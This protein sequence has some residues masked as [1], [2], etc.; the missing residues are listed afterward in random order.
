MAFEP[1]DEQLAILDH[2]PG[3]HARVLAGPGTGKST[4]MVALLDRLLKADESLRVRMLT[5]T[6]AA[7]TELAEKVAGLS[8]D[9]ERPSTIHSFSIS[10]LLRN[11]G[12]GGFPEPLRLAD[13]WEVH[14][15]VRPTL[16]KRVGVR[17]RLLDKLIQ[18]MAANW[19]SLTAEEDETI[20]EADR[21]RFGGAWKEHRRVLG[22]TLLQELPYALRRALHDHDDLDGID[23]DLLV[24]DEYQDLNSCD[25][26]VIKLLSDKGGCAVIGT[27]DD[28]QSIYSWRKA[29]PEGIRRFLKDYDEAE[30]YTLSVTLRCGSQ[31]IEW[32]NHVIQGDPDRPSGRAVLDPAPACPEGEVALLSFDGEGEEARGIA[33]LVESL[34][35]D[36]IE[37]KDILVLTRTDN[38]GTFS[39]PI[40]AELEKRGIPCSDTSYVR[41]IL[42]DR[43]NRKLL[44]VLRLVVNPNDAISW[45]SILCLADGVGPSFFDYIYDRA[46]TKGRSFAEELLDAHT[47]DFPGAPASARK[48]R[49]VMRDTLASLDEIELPDDDEQHDWGAWIIELCNNDDTLPKPTPDFHDLL[50]RLDETIDSSESLGRYLGQIE[51]LGKDMA[52]A[53][54]N[55]VRIMTMS[56]SKGLTV[57][58]TIIAGVED[59]LVPRPD[60]DLSEE[61]RILYVAM[62][63]AREYLFCTWAKRRRGPTARAGDA[64]TSRR[65]HCHFLDDGPVESQNGRAFIDAR[66]ASR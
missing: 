60:C 48:V 40:R 6:R 51:P 1:T 58:A 34:V 47:K 19:E 28:D 54:S 2:D 59:E 12:T 16:A 56:G 35:E 53:Q 17:V 38:N 32:A 10:V 15:V 3:H 9:A 29:A 5:F 57:R 66:T 49:M 14:N 46:K 22:Y 25:L 64:S 7:T 42:D 23:F 27:G 50:V 43:D 45:A 11:P 55:G 33:A 4:T 61:R 31:I 8:A 24:V 65:R 63:R 21:R 26:E 30:D 20:D 44:E 13:T 37:A 18:E 62:T 41:L 52:Q 39:K 36:G